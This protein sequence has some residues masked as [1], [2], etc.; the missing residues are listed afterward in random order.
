[1]CYLILTVR[2]IDGDINGLLE[3][4]FYGLFADLNNFIGYI[5]THR[6]MAADQIY[7]CSS[8]TLWRKKTKK[9]KQIKIL[10]DF[11]LLHSVKQ[12]GNT[13]RIESL[14]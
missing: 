9:K 1:M 2:H 3:N 14:Y 13:F 10:R 6:L 7:I 8:D 5:L 11:V 4:L 12:I